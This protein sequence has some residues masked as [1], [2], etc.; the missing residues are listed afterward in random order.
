MLVTD[1]G[2][3]KQNTGS[4][5]V[6]IMVIDINDNQPQF[7]PPNVTET[8]RENS[9]SSGTLVVRLTTVDDDSVNSM[10]RYYIVSGN[11]GN[12]FALDDANGELQ[13]NVVFDREEQASYVLVV[14]AE[15]NGS[16]SL[17]GTSYVTIFITDDD[18]S[19]P[20]NAET[21]VFIY[22]YCRTK[23]SPRAG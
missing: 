14:T 17:T 20:T 10:I 18:D 12:Q 5:Q 4:A 15:D 13:S 19:Q 16:P 1:K 11:E 2:V 7:L 22:H 21:N 9:A 6:T 23:L 3:E 8:V